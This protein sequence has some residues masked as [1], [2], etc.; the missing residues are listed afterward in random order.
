MAMH[1]IS[2]ILQIGCN[3]LVLCIIVFLFQFSLCSCYLSLGLA[4]M[5]IPP[6]GLELVAKDKPIEFSCIEE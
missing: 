2:Y 3:T 1:I 4:Y 6:L 5:H